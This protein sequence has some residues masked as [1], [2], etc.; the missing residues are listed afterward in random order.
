MWCQSSCDIDCYC[1]YS[2]KSGTRCSHKVQVSREHQVCLG[3]P[4]LPQ[5][6]A[7]TVTKT[8]KAKL[9]DKICNALVFTVERV[10]SRACLQ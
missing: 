6:V 5:Q 2:I 8:N 9:I 10:Y 4:L 7:S 1:D 3:S